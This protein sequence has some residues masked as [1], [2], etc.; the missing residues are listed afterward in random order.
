MNFISTRGKETNVKSSKAIINGISV[1]GGLYVPEKFPN[2]FKDLKENIN[3]NFDDAQTGLK[4]IFLDLSLRE[5]I[6][7]N[8]K[9]S[10]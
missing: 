8:G 5:K 7:N 3:Y 6:N 2:I 10:L 4:E 1:D 9:I